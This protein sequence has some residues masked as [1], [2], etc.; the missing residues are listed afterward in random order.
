MSVFDAHGVLFT[1]CYGYSDIENG[2]RADEETV[3]EWG[4]NSK[5]L[6]W[7]S[8]MQLWERGLLDLEADIRDYL[9]EG[10]LTKLQYPDEKITM[11][12]LMAH[13]AGFQESFYED[14]QASPDEVYDSLEDALRACEC[15][16]AYH[17]GE[18]TAY[19]NW[20]NALAAYIVGRVSGTDYVTYVHENIL[21]PLGMAHTSVDANMADNDW[22]RQ[23]R[24]LL[25]CYGRYAEAKYNEDYGPSIYGIQLFPA[26]AATGTI[27]DFARFGQALVA[28]DCPLFEKRA[29][30]DEMFRPL[31]CYGDTGIAKNC[32]GFWTSEHR[33]QTLGHGGNT[34][35]TA[36]I[37]FDPEGGLGIVVM[38][39]EPG[40]T[41]F[42]S[43]L[44]G[45][46]FGDVTDRAE[47]RNAP[48]AGNPDISGVY[49]M[50]RTI[51]RGAG[52]A[53]GFMGGLFPWSGNDD[54]TY[55]MRLFGKT[56]GSA[57]LVPIAQ[58]RYVMRD[59]GMDTFIFDN[60]GT[61]EMMTTDLIRI[62]PLWTVLCYAFI[63]FG[64]ACLL[65]LPVKLVAR[66]VRKLRKRGRK[67]A[68][69][70]RQ[71]LA[72]Q[73][74]CGVSGVIFALFILI[75]GSSSRAFT[76]VSAILAA[77]LA[78]ASLVNGGLL[79]YN[80]IK[81]DAKARAKVKRFIWAAL[82]AA[83]AAFI[84]VMQLYNFWDL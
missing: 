62:S 63:L 76:T 47:Y 14:Q 51:A 18:F 33:V 65:A 26:G 9:P 29:T 69:A 58:D 61:L 12:N 74:L 71:I 72:Q 82:A 66:I 19:S 5:L 23:R 78:L 2:V 53:S 54:G 44:P 36:N 17:V 27:G 84:V 43:G 31:T 38:T 37:E 42:C 7:V 46:L 3:Y 55:S 34:M 45:L 57:T 40:E 15:C 39:N 28:A 80:T 30:R 32:H 75:I 20:G 24:A 73:L 6:V 35:C 50:K 41:A 77:I 1:G 11:L 68:A 59:N 22:V 48:F 8:A 13:N 67:C 79:C 4:S 56:F 70:D 60:R 16:Q 21:A 52:M 25:K 49:R 83:Y 10:F 64:L 81:S